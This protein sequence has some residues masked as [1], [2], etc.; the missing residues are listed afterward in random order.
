[1]I[2]FEGT[3]MPG[4]IVSSVSDGAG[5]SGDPVLGSVGGHAWGDRFGIGTNAA[6]IF[7]SDCEGTCSG[8]DEDLGVFSGNI[9]IV[10][11]D[12]AGIDPDDEG[13]D[14]PIHFRFDTRTSAP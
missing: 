12:L 9:L 2:D 5:I 10:S 1:M 3:R 11:E 8:G 4:D 14:F 6:M 7:D 13:F